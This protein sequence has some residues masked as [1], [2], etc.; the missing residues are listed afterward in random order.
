MSWHDTYAVFK[1][2]GGRLVPRTLTVCG[3]PRNDR[4]LVAYPHLARLLTKVTPHQQP[5]EGNRP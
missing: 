3:A 1:T 4:W 5:P 2:A